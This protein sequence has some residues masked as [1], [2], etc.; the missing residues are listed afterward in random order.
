MDKYILPKNLAKYGYG[1]DD[2]ARTAFSVDEEG[3]FDYESLESIDD[4]I[5]DE[6]TVKVNV[7]KI[8]TVVDNLAYEHRKLL[9]N[10]SQYFELESIIPLHEI[11]EKFDNDN[12]IKLALDY[13]ISMG[14]KIRGNDADMESEQENYYRH[15]DNAKINLPIPYERDYQNQ[16]LEQLITYRNILCSLMYLDGENVSFEKKDT[17]KLNMDDD[18]EE[19][20]AFKNKYSE[21]FSE[22][23]RI[24]GEIAEHNMRLVN[25]W[26]YKQK[27]K[28]INTENFISTG[29]LILFKAIDNYVRK[30]ENLKNYALSTFICNQ[31]NWMFVKS[32]K[33]I[34]EYDD[35]TF[36]RLPDYIV[37]QINKC[38]KVRNALSEFGE[39]TSSEIG[40]ALGLYSERVREL[41]MLDERKKVLSL[42]ELL[43][44]N[45]D[46]EIYSVGLEKPMVYHDPELVAEFN[47][48][49]ESVSR[50]LD[51]LSERER[52]VIELRFGLKDGYQ[53][54]L[55]EVAREFG[56]T[57]ERI[58]QMESKVLA[59]LRRA[60]N[61]SELNK[62]VVDGVSPY[63]EIEAEYGGRTL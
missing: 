51:R 54:T 6:E 1:C 59:K 34:A 50:V 46:L 23:Y 57:R 32:N 14:Y 33:G 48:V 61:S 10:G 24:R 35:T 31:L 41:E 37:T 16:L 36:I 11:K 26:F 15:A 29:Y 25:W 27:I 40:G 63:S 17:I 60:S 19:F 8:I 62:Y 7:D 53:R 43:S 39:P 30:P 58:A 49:K 38:K 3:L 13:A 47:E 5:L 9:K 28:E 42:D 12:E 56:V 18:T 44:Q 52:K 20:L 21:I 2:P 22:Y 4:D 55:E 45:P